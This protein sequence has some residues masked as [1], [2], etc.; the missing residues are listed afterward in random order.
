VR[1]RRQG[2]YSLTESD[3]NTSHSQSTLCQI[4]GRSLFYFAKA[5][6]VRT[7][8]HVAFGSGPSSA[9]VISRLSRFFANCVVDRRTKLIRYRIT[10]HKRKCRSENFSSFLLLW[11]NTRSSERKR[12]WPGAGLS[13]ML[14]SEFSLALFSYFVEMVRHQCIATSFA[15]IDIRRHRDKH[16]REFRARHSTWAKRKGACERNTLMRSTQ[17]VPVLAWAWAWGG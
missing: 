17:S 12:K 1:S 15:V 6:G 5:F 11:A 10:K 2:F 8:P 7:R 4:H 16:S 14:F 13:A 9:V 3:A